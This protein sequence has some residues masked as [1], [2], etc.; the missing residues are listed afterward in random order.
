MD[1]N[2]IDGARKTLGLGE[3]ATLEEIRSAY[4]SLVLKYHPDRCAEKD[5]EEYAEIFKKITRA[6][7]TIM[8][9]CASYK[10]SFKKQD[11]EK[12]TKEED[13]D[14]EHLKNFYDGWFGKVDV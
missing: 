5:R 2:K 9:Y 3:N 1:F 14:K 12:T 8:V 10:Y 7:E 13:M 6:Y 4:R 11:V